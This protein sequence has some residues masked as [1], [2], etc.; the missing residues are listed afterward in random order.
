MVTLIESK[1]GQS[2]KEW[3]RTGFNTMGDVSDGYHSFNDLYFYR[4]LYNALWIKNM[5]E[6][7]KREL[8][9]HKSWKHSDGELCFGGGWFV[10]VATLPTGQITNHYE[11]NSWDL[12]DCEERETADEWDGHT[13][14]EAA[15]RMYEYLKD[16]DYNNKSVGSF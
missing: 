8:N 10:V 11:A 14:T 7:T 6:A 5:D 4:K 15:S 3:K 9:V 1:A 2:E 13:A 12:F 16:T